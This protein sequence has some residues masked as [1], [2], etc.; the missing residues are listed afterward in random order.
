MDSLAETRRAESTAA[1]AV[2]GRPAPEF[3]AYPDTGLAAARSNRA[4]GDPGQ[5]GD[6]QGVPHGEA[7]GGLPRAEPDGQHALPLRVEERREVPEHLLVAA[8]A[9]GIAGD[10]PSER[11]APVLR[12][13]LVAA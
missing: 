6:G 8:E 2:L 5:P 11:G 1:A 3:L 7:G 10:L 4:A 13:S 12:P 9:Q